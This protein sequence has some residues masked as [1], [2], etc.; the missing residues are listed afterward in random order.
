MNQSQAIT[1][2]ALQVKVVEKNIA[3]LLDHLGHDIPVDAPI[4]L[5]SAIKATY[6]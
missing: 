6:L 5:H 4:C 2:R 3:T 1:L